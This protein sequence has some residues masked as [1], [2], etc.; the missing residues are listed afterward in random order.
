MQSIRLQK[1]CETLTKTINELKQRNH[2]LEENNREEML[3]MKATLREKNTKH[4]NELIELEAKL[5]K[6]ILYES[7]KSAE[8]KTKIEQTKEEY[9]KL[10]RKSADCLHQTT[11][12]LEEKF[13][14]KLKDRDDQIRT[15][16]DEIQN[17]KEEFVHYCNQ[18]NLDND[19]KMAQIS[20]K[21]ETQ[22]KKTNDELSKWRTEASILAKKIDGSSSSYIQLKDNVALLTEENNKNKK[23]ICQLEQKLNDLQQEIELRNGLVDDKES[24]L[25]NAIEKNA[26]S[27]TEKPIQ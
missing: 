13:T 27:P 16:L 20:L 4:A 19:R 12:T 10:L 17:K 9:E 25:K 22:L 15:L 23:Y 1:T 8:M 24:C 18:L 11:K 21:Y 3:V 2:L 5:C 6:K 7:N 26:M 14:E